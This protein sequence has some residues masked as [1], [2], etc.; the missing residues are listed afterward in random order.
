MSQDPKDLGYYRYAYH[1]TISLDGEEVKDCFTADEELGICLCHRR[2]DHGE[3]LRD[4][5]GNIRVMELKG[6]IE[7]RRIIFNRT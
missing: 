3:Y 1:F 4:K 6:D 2:N 5:N 7:I